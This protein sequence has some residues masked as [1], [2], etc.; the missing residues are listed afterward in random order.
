M[1][2]RPDRRVLLD[3][4]FKKPRP[5]TMGNAKGDPEVLRRNQGSENRELKVMFGSVQYAIPTLGW[6]RVE[7][8]QGGIVAAGNGCGISDVWGTQTS[9]TYQAGT[10]VVVAVQ[11]DSNLA[12]IIGQLPSRVG[13]S[14][15]FFNQ[16]TFAG[17]WTG[18]R[19]DPAARFY[20]ES[21]DQAGGSY[22]YFLGQN[23][24]QHGGDT[25]IRGSLG[26][27]IMIDTFMARIA[28]DEATGLTLGL[29][30]QF[31][32][33]SGRDMEIQSDGVLL[34][35][36][37][38]SQTARLGLT[39][40]SLKRLKVE[41]DKEAKT[42]R[43]TLFESADIEWKPEDGSSQDEFF[44][45]VQQASI[46]LDKWPV[47]TEMA[48]GELYYAH[49]TV[50]TP[51]QVY[52]FNVSAHTG[53]QIKRSL[54]LGES[55]LIS[56]ADIVML[57]KNLAAEK[58]A[59]FI[60]EADKL[61]TEASLASWKSAAQINAPFLDV[62]YQ[63]AQQLAEFAK[64][65]DMLEEVT[66]YRM[67]SPKVS[68]SDTAFLDSYKFGDSAAFASRI[69]VGADAPSE[70][71]S[72]R[73]SLFSEFL[74]PNVADKKGVIRQDDAGNIFIYNEAGAG[75]AIVGGKLYLSAMEISIVS[76]RDIELLCRDLNANANRDAV[77][78]ANKNV[79]LFSEKSVEILSGNSGTGGTLIECRGAGDTFEF[80]IDPKQKK[81]HGLFIKSAQAPIG[82]VGGDIGI[83]AGESDIGAT[84][85]LL[86]NNSSGDT[87]VAGY[88]RLVMHASSTQ[89][90]TFGNAWRQPS[91]AIVHYE[92][93]SLF[94]G[95]VFG[96]DLWSAGTVAAVSN[97]VTAY[98]EVGK[99]NEP[100]TI[101]Q[102]VQQFGTQLKVANES[103]RASAKE[104][105]ERITAKGKMFHIDTF[106]TISV[107]FGEVEGPDKNWYGMHWRPSA[108]FPSLLGLKD[109]GGQWEPFAQMVVRYRPDSSP[110]DSYAWPGSIAKTEIDVPKE[111]VST[112]M[113]VDKLLGKD[114]YSSSVSK[115][116]FSQVF[117]TY[118]A[119]A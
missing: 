82:I 69:D 119:K 9:R 18:F 3:D 94:P 81:M 110:Q 91:K 15:D 5:N 93:Q 41:Q 116:S 72:Q 20:V 114:D 108:P 74:L 67:F 103:W 26:N 52:Q 13:S 85:T 89:M 22:G 40:L 8:E 78:T 98:G 43:A 33:L 117:R 107:S 38:R 90:Q 102:G 88:G 86:L 92:T 70:Q 63:Y 11:E 77:V 71:A 14:K 97:I 64:N 76:A 80:S 105:H 42:A 45:K 113:Q 59:G 57:P 106:R 96:Q 55:M 16:P 25:V 21:L 58:D 53:Y 115:A 35:S 1:A 109:R 48:A 31:V 68:P 6:H 83:Q 84:G 10:Q 19:H 29:L 39:G 111:D 75:L 36:D 28:V 44:K 61:I 12:S 30:D 56:A 4:S 32:G 24:D 50:A 17:S 46:S 79:R 60:L 65:K 49:Q 101:T 7:L 95:V 118:K 73:K 34:R 62:G 2:T 54:L 112:R 47:Y 66:P 27:L 104:T 37:R 23:A 87:V 51:E 100:S 99:T